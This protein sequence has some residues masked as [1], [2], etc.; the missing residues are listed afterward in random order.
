[1]T[2][3]RCFNQHGCSL[4]LT[5][6]VKELEVTHQGVDSI[7]SP[8][9]ADGDQSGGILGFRTDGTVVGCLLAAKASDCLVKM[10]RCPMPPKP[11]A[12]CEAS[13]C[14]HGCIT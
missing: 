8:G 9:P 12:S 6:R 7:E 14:Q 11:S 10:F 4:L 2:F 3:Q 13:Q 5:G 1:M